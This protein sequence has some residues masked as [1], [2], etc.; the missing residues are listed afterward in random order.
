MTTERSDIR[1]SGATSL[2]KGLALLDVDGT[3]TFPVNIPQSAPKM[4]AFRLKKCVG[5]GKG[6]KIVEVPLTGTVGCGGI[7]DA[8][9]QYLASQRVGKVR[10]PGFN[11]TIDLRGV[12]DE[13]GRTAP[14]GISTCCLRS[15]GTGVDA[16]GTEN[17]SVLEPKP[18]CIA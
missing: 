17:E 5:R 4:A 13:P 18:I 11:I 1:D 16:R 7:E 3:E 6:E 12:A 15:D 2:S 9:T 10:W 8:G 14:D